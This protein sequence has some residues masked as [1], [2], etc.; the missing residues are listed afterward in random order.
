M[1][2]NKENWTKFNKT[3]LILSLSN[4]ENK[5]LKIGHYIEFFKRGGEMKIFFGI[6]GPM[7]FVHRPVF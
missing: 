4:V 7:D 5:E 6:T 3:P 2:A 1:L